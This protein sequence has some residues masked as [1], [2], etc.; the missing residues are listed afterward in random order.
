ME[1]NPYAPDFDLLPETLPVFPL[2]GVLLLPEG[3]LPLHIFEPRYVEMFDQAFSSHRLIGMVQPTPATQEADKPDLHKVGCAG[4]ITEFSETADGRYM[5][6]LTGIGRFEVKQELSV[7]TPYR[8]VKADWQRFKDDTFKASCLDL[9]R[10]KLTNLLQDYFAAQDME[11]DWNAIAEA[12]DGGLITCLSMVCPFE[13]QEKQ[14]L[15]EA[16]CCR[17]RADMF[18]TMLEM[19]VR[20]DSKSPASQH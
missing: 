19:A 18:M 8:Q 17:T 1:R 12:S 10:A 11:C 7:T 15:L 5:L 4:R 2:S 16:P 14:A 20:G 9:D 3:K 6:V 13:P